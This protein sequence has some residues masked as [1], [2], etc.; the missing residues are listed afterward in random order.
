MLCFSFLLCDPDWDRTFKTHSF[1]A[2]FSENP[3]P[4]V[5]PTGGDLE[6]AF[7]A[8]NL[9]PAGELEGGFPSL[10]PGRTET[11][12]ESEGGL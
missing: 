4:Q 6:G 7:V 5:S 3:V 12:L 2:S 10:L 11:K 9:P 8:A 1:L